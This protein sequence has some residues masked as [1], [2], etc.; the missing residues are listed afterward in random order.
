MTI[1][2]IQHQLLRSRTGQ[3]NKLER[4]VIK[5]QLIRINRLF[6]SRKRQARSAAQLHTSPVAR[7]RLHS[8]ATSP[9]ARSAWSATAPVTTRSAQLH[10]VLALSM[11]RAMR[12]YRLWI[13]TCNAVLLVSVV[14]FIIIGS[15]I[16]VFD[17]KRMLIPNF[18]LTQP[19]LI[20]AY[21]ALLF[22]S[23]FLQFIGCVG[24]IKLN[25]KLLNIYWLLLL[26]LLFGDVM[27]GIFWVYRYKDI[28]Q[29]LGPDL[30][31]RLV[32][33]YPSDPNYRELWDDTQTEF[34]CC[35]VDSFQDYILFNSSYLQTD[36]VSSASGV[37]K[38]TTTV[39]LPASCCHGAA[40]GG[41]GASAGGPG[42]PVAEALRPT[43][44][45]HSTTTT[46]TPAPPSTTSEYERDIS[47]Y[48]QIFHC[49]GAGAGDWEAPPGAP[50]ARP[51]R[52]LATPYKQGC[53]DRVAQWIKSRAD[54][55][56][57]LGFCVI[58]FLKLC[59]LGIL[60]YEIREMIQ[61]I[62][63][64]QEK[65]AEIEAEAAFAKQQAP[66][67]YEHNGGVIGVAK[68]TNQE[69]GQGSCQARRDLLGSGMDMDQTR[70]SPVLVV[71]EQERLSAA[72]AGRQESGTMEMLAPGYASATSRRPPM[73]PAQSLS[74][75][76]AS[77]PNGPAQ[78]YVRRDCE[79]DDDEDEEDSLQNTPLLSHS[80]S[81]PAAAAYANPS[82][83]RLQRS[84]LS[85][86]LNH[87]DYA[88]DS[89]T[90][91][92]CALLITH[93]GLPDPEEGNSGSERKRKQESYRGSHSTSNGKSSGSNGNSYEMKEM[94]RSQGACSHSHSQSQSRSHSHS[95]GSSQE[96]SPGSQI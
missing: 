49:P 42:R 45:V 25:E 14:C 35:G 41:G 64:L 38:M 51:P 63:I 3:L 86:I 84:F 31:Y 11:N 66:K 37:E 24:A 79:G 46:T 19:S 32:F 8:A 76:S 47:L 71:N 30:K 39:S 52:P 22:Q 20:Y 43:H 60:R 10:S 23:G 85:T 54:I 88:N 27:L 89:D 12:Y 17:S 7:S 28:M 50:H 56:F 93:D 62:K 65:R 55:L 58:S 61:K 34:Q 95:H 6:V 82:K 87:R 90:N 33:Q 1:M 57:V 81:S 96:L 68:E 92:H 36:A 70:L 94:S 44:Y 69:P 29:Q 18:T 9:V 74:Y 40:A 78:S 59:F 5:D 53:H 77:P 75:S 26:L 80:A 13:Y 2:L 15:K 73:T 91:S 16:I 48:S 4:D 67:H 83:S 21:S 72:A